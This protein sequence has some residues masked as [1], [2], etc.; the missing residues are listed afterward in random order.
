MAGAAGNEAWMNLEG[1]QEQQIIE[2]WYSNAA[3]WFIWDRQG[4]TQ[5]A[6]LRLM[7]LK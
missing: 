7:E 1:P 6:D 5:G 2:S 4:A 3:P